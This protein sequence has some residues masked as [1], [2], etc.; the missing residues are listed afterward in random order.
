[1]RTFSSPSKGPKL[2]ES[3][4]TIPK[5]N[6]SI[7]TNNTEMNLIEREDDSPIIEIN[8][9]RLNAKITA[10]R[11][12]VE[13]NGKNKIFDKS[14][15]SLTD[16]MAKTLKTNL[17]DLIAQHEMQSYASPSKPMHVGQLKKQT[18]IPSSAEKMPLH[19]RSSSSYAPQSS[20]QMKEQPKVSQKSEIKG[21]SITRA[22]TNGPMMSK[23]SMLDISDDEESKINPIAMMS[24]TNTFVLKP[25]FHLNRSSV[26][27][28]PVV[29]T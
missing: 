6:Q 15:N 14:R 12:Q 26:G 27:V 9:D 7:D 18:I 17:A 25:N 22:E 13:Q 2:A 8:Y 4:R 29:N 3:N 21:P 1:M 20:N 19:I 11:A 10:K 24:Q 5:L 23:G 28:Y 16:S